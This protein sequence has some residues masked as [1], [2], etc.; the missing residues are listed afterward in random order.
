MAQ[1]DI[2]AKN[3]LALGRAGY[4]QPFEAM[5]YGWKAGAQHYWCGTRD[6]GNVWHCQRRLKSDPLWRFAPVET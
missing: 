6:Q 4:H 1:H 2:G 3:T 5:L